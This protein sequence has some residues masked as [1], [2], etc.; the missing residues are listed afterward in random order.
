MASSM[1]MASNGQLGF[2][3]FG[4]WWVDLHI[5]SYSLNHRSKVYTLVEVLPV[6]NAYT[7]SWCKTLKISPKI[8]FWKQK[9]PVVYWDMVY[10][11]G[12]GSTSIGVHPFDVYSLCWLMGRGLTGLATRSL[13]VVP[14][15]SLRFNVNYD[16][17]FL[18]IHAV[19]LQ[20]R[21]PPGVNF[22]TPTIYG[23]PM[24]TMFISVID[25]FRYMY[26][27]DW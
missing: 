15:W 18:H 23:N 5:L 1:G 16:F 21:V 6:P 14:E 10:T 7:T 25:N 2:N 4:F 17:S 8:A 3:G 26:E 9:T 13:E 27:F 19:W 22:L 20:L 24:I 11:L 12:T